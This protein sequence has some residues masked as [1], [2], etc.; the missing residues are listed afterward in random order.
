MKRY[1]TLTNLILIPIALYF[2]VQIFYGITTAQLDSGSLLSKN[3]QATTPFQ[4]EANFPIT[5]YK[6]II[7]RNLFKTRKGAVQPKAVDINVGS[8][9]PTTLKLKLLGTVTGTQ[10][11]AYAVIQDEKDRQQNLFRV[12]D[13]IQDAIL[14]AILREKVVLR[15]NGK[16][17]ILE[18]EK[19][20]SGSG[21]RRSS[22]SSRETRT[23]SS[24][25][26]PKTQ[27]INLKRS[28]LDEAIANVGD[29]MKDVNIQPHFEDGRPA[30]LRLSRIKRQ[31]IFRKMGLRRG[32]I[33]VGVDGQRIESV[34]DAL[35]LYDSLTSASNV[36]LEI[37]RKGQTRILDYNIK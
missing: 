29:L 15:V 25:N 17:E 26:V 2:T 1:F 23:G 5:F 22:R 24:R 3:R 18:I 19:I 33:I 12:G 36:K 14:K 34:D 13:A 35:A 11:S 37:K 32:D 8:L 20:R 7:E 6:P 21:R 16:D 31:S 28:L 30:G 27:R 10:G 4:R 9:E